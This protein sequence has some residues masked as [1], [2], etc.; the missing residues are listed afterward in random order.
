MVTSSHTHSKKGFQKYAT[1]VPC[2]L[3]LWFR[4]NQ[5]LIANALV[6]KCKNA[7]EKRTLSN[8]NDRSVACFKAAYVSCNV[9][10]FR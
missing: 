9:G 6:S 8:G 2:P 7:H 3:V 5:Y 4:I 1:C 10:L